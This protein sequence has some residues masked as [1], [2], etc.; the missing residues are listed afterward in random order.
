MGAEESNRK[1]GE[2]VIFVIRDEHNECLFLIV[3]YI[4]IQLHSDGVCV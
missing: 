1:R 4:F 2:P 3:V